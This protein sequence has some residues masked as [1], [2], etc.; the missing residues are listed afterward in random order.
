VGA[1]GHAE[2]DGIAANVSEFGWFGG[3]MV[4]PII[5]EE[6]LREK[7]ISEGE[8][9]SSTFNGSTIVAGADGRKS[10]QQVFMDACAPCSAMT[11]PA[12]EQRLLEG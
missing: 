2:G 4:A 3:V 8:M 6:L 9:G 11:L 1:A 5:F 7:G 12:I 10:T